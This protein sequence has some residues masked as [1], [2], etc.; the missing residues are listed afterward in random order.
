L[1]GVNIYRKGPDGGFSPEP[2]NRK[3]VTGNNFDDFAL[4]NDKTYQYGLRTVVK[5]E[6]ATVESALSEIVT[7]TPHSGL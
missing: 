1:L 2:I 6:K 3:P 4:E 5:I 7:A